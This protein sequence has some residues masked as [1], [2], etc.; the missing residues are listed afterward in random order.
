M[1]ERDFTG[2]A[3]RSSRD[4]VRSPPIESDGLPDLR[5]INSQPILDVAKRAGFEIT[6]EGHPICLHAYAE[7]DGRSRIMRLSS[8]NRAYC[9]YCREGPMSAIDML[10]HAG[11]LDSPRDA[12]M[13]FGLHKWAPAIA[14]GSHLN[15][16]EGLDT[17]PACADPM[18]FLVKSGLWATFTETVKIMIPVFLTMGD[19][20]PDNIIALSY[21]AMARYSGVK[22]HKAISIALKYLA[23][24]GWFEPLDP[25][26]RGNSPVRA[27][28]R[29]KLTPLSSKMK[30]KAAKTAPAF[31]DAI[32]DEK[33]AR[34]QARLKRET[35]LRAGQA[36]LTG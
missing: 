10:M 11:N 29:Y 18:S 25:E 20:K 36:R 6:P 21:R 34:A 26:F 28:A 16:P 3:T 14:R 8:D 27:T 4:G 30:A 22:S 31:G 7:T 15:N 2:P 32:K 19:G 24:I 17:P 33:K 9:E 12:V 5:W 1:P 13:A 35:Q 23:E